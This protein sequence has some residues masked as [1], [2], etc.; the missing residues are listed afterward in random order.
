M[1][2]SYSKE[3]DKEV[4]ITQNAA[5]SNNAGTSEIEKHII[6]NNILLTV[7][8]VIFLAGAIYLGCK[9]WRRSERNWMEGRMQAEYFR[10]MRQ[11]L[12]GRFNSTDGGD[13]A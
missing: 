12:S 2:K 1:G 7:A 9:C 10:R 3:E 13:A 11:R 4:I 8:L 6:T 5:G